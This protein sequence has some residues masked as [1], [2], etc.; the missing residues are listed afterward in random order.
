MR[1][2]LSCWGASATRKTVRSSFRERKD[3]EEEFPKYSL[4]CKL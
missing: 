2:Q 1:N 4:C 3:K